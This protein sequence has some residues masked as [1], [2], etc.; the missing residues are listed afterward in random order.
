M[1]TGQIHG[2]QWGHGARDWAT[3]VEP[4]FH[5]LYTMVHDRIQVGEGTRLLDVGCGPGGSVALACVRVA[6]VAGLDASSGSIAVARERVPSG[7]FQVGDMESLPWPNGAF[8]A[9]TGFNSFQ[10]ASNPTNALAE[11]RRV[12]AA[13]GRLGMVIWAP[14]EMSEQPRIMGATTALAPPQ[15]PNAPGPFALSSPGVVDSVLEGAG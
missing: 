6:R 5:S 9:V 4:Y 7:D 11:A 12:L 13:G 1:T 10:F 8:D 3:Y 15:P 2:E 14:K